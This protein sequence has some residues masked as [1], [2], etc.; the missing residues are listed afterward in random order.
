MK[1]KLKKDFLVLKK[2]V[3]GFIKEFKK[4]HGEDTIL[5]NAFESYS[6]DLT[7]MIYQHVDRINNY[8]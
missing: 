4:V 7:E 3:E 5:I 6:D 1:Q 8:K 2:N